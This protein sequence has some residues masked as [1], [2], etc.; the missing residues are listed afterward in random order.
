MSS[1]LNSLNAISIDIFKRNYLYKIGLLV[2]IYFFWNIYYIAVNGVINII[3]KRII[4][5]TY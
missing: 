5:S 3:Y 1:I 2:F 4:P